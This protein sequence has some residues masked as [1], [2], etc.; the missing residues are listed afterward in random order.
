[1][2]HEVITCLCTRVEGN[3]KAECQV[4]GHGNV[5]NLVD[6]QAVVDAGAEALDHIDDAIQSILKARRAWVS[7]GLDGNNPFPTSLDELA[8]NM[9]FQWQ[10]L[11]K[12]TA[13]AQTVADRRAR[14]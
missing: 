10:E 9:T 6:P 7:R 12:F 8:R 1:M 4:P 5:P 3:R 13:A 2:S 11:R 14:Q